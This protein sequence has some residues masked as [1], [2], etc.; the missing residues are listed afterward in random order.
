MYY[1]DYI[2]SYRNKLFGILIKSKMRLVGDKL[3]E[4]VKNDRLGT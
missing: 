2:K 1:S 3:L 4:N